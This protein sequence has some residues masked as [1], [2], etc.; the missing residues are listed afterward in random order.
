MPEEIA[1]A[2]LAL[3]EAPLYIVVALF[4]AIAAMTA[5]DERGVDKRSRQNVR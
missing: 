4:V 3:P 5:A 2:T 1:A